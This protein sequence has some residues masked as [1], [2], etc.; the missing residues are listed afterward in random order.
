MGNEPDRQLVELAYTIL[1]SVFR[2]IIKQL[3]EPR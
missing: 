1:S 2:V 3:E